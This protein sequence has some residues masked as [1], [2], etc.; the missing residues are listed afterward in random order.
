[1]F[2]F[3]T[4]PPFPVEERNKL[5]IGIF[6]LVFGIVLAVTGFFYYMLRAKGQCS[7]NKLIMS[8]VLHNKMDH[9]FLLITITVMYVSEKVQ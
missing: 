6:F 3:R 5:I 4:D 1:M 9:F 7:E 2:V 8:V